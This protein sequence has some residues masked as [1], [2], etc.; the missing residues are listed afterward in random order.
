MRW[1][2][3]KNER[4]K[5]KTLPHHLRLSCVVRSA[6]RAE[7]NFFSPGKSIPKM[8]I[9]SWAGWQA[10]KL[11]AESII[12]AQRW[13]SNTFAFGVSNIKYVRLDWYDVYIDST[14]APRPRSYL[15]A[16]NHRHSLEDTFNLSAEA[17]P[18]KVKCCQCNLSELVS[19]FCDV[20][21]L[22]NSL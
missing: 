13:K 19:Q 2:K 21:S 9:V 7:D 8:R 16:R 22:C 11:S 4:W 5:F 15:P 10:N 14:L 6:S 1:R 3:T 12:F 20:I 17:S 18:V